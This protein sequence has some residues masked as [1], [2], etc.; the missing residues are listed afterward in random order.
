MK[1]FP[2]CFKMSS[3]ETQL[4]ATKLSTGA[5]LSRQPFNSVKSCS[6]NCRQLKRGGKGVLQ[7][8][9][10]DA[11]SS[12]CIGNEKKAHIF[13][14]ASNGVGAAE[15]TAPARCTGV[16][17][18][19]AF[20]PAF[21]LLSLSFRSQPSLSHINTQGAPL[22]DQAHSSID[23][24]CVHPSSLPILCLTST[25]PSPARPHPHP[26]VCSASPSW[27]PSTSHLILLRQVRD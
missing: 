9:S 26:S 10:S 21:S 20:W 17:G 5:Y 24:G 15:T 23:Q 1:S 14:Q 13:Q 22:L 16:V 7:S 6:D 11:G 19:Q 2:G 12:G 8:G 3:A 18:F 4:N 27:S 25:P